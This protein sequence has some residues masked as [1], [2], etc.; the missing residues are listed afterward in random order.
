MGV[1]APPTLN[2]SDL[3][4]ATILRPIACRRCT[5]SGSFS[6]ISRQ[7][8]T[9]AMV[10]GGMD[11]LKISGPGH[12]LDVVDHVVVTRDEPAQGAEGLGERAHD[13]VRVIRDAVVLFRAPAASFPGRPGR[14]PRP[15]TAVRR[16]VRHSSFIRGSFTMSPSMLKTPSVTTSLGASAALPRGT[17]PG[18]PCCCAW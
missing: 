14:A 5:R 2:P 9:E 7:A 1:S 6:M 8:P 13:D 4:P 17:S 10:A 3:N 12:V 16:T 18:F 15:G 11:A